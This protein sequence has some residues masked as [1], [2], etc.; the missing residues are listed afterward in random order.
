MLILNYSL[1]YSNY[2]WT[3][4]LII[5]LFSYLFLLGTSFKVFKLSSELQGA[6]YYLL[7]SLLLLINSFYT[8]NLVSDLVCLCK[9][10][11]L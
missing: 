1:T 6:P 5:L 9:G 8:C 3:I 4:I 2:F 7:A 10:L 11:Y